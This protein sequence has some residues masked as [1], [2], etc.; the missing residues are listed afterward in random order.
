V[1]HLVAVDTDD[2]MATVAEKIA[3]HTIGRRLPA[4]TKAQ[5]YEVTID[6]VVIPASMTFG[7]VLGERQLAPLHWVTVRWKQ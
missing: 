1:P 3:V 5:G 7:Q 4:R 2:T 6:D